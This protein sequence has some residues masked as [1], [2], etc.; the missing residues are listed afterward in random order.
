M[1]LGILFWLFLAIAIAGLGPTVINI[2]KKWWETKS[3]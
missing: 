2:L 1:E 3:W